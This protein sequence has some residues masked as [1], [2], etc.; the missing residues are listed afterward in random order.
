M[1][2]QEEIERLY[3]DH[4]DGFEAKRFL[5]LWNVYVNAV[6]DIIDEKISDSEF[7]L[8]AFNLATELYSMP[9]YVKYM[10]IL[11]FA[12][13]ESHHCYADSC[14][15]EKSGISW[16]ETQADFL[17]ATSQLTLSI[18]E[19]LGGYD[20]RRQLSILV[21]EDSFNKHHDKDGNR[22]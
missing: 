1:N 12:I 17:R 14:L 9:F 13:K 20:K 18:I 6:D 2:F 5:T 15:M 3:L 11:Y 21:R 22:H 7:I 19:I 16:Q 8:K 10:G 4:P